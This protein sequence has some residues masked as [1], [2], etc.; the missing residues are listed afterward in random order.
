MVVVR[1]GADGATVDVT[2]E[3]FSVR[4]RV[5][6]YGG[7]A[8]LVADGVVFFSNFAD[9]RMYRQDPGV[10][11]RAITPEAELR[12][13]DAILDGGR[14]ASFAFGKTTLATERRS[15]P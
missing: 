14:G 3:P 12:Y 4:A 8:F 10:P 7:G 2:P 9:Q 15:M 1:K 6:E 13:A 11:P 5:H